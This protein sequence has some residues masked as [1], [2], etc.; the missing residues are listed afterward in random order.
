MSKRM[1]LSAGDKLGPYEIVALVGKGGMGEVYRGTDTRLG[2]SAAIRVSSREFNDRF[3]REACAV[4]ALNHPNICRLHELAGAPP[5]TLCTSVGAVGSGAWNQ[6]G[7]IV[8]GGRG[9]GALRG[10]SAAG[11][12]PK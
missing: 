5:Q 11:G 9:T 7:V 3:E 4:S 2:R 1:Q 12:V 6:A 8:F 10:V